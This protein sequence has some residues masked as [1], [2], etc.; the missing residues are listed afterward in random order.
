MK[1]NYGVCIGIDQLDRIEKMAELG[2]DFAE[3]GFAA[4]AEASEAQID[5]FG[6]ALREN[7]MTCASCNGFMPGS[8]KTCGPDMD[9]AKIKDYL[10]RNFERSAKLGFKSVI[11][12]S[13]GSR[14]V[15]EGYDRERAKADIMHFL[16]DLVVPVVKQYDITIG[17][18]EL[19]AEETNIINTCAEA[20]E[21]ITA[22]NDPHI[23]LLVDLYHVAVMGT[24]VEELRRYKGYVSHV[25][26]ASPSNGR[27][28]PLPTDGDDALYRQFYDILEEI[29]Y[30][31]KNVSLEGSCGDDFND[32]ITKSIAYLKSIEK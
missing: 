29:G 7:G 5:A 12:G 18:E 19:R 26:I 30:E 11:F 16:G 21:Y 22:I 8:I 24:P 2:Y 25:H 15:P 31:A 28:Y 32:T 14:Q 4:M 10:E 3:T 27:I 6:K 20:W 1:F 23:K 17:I 13:G 9:D